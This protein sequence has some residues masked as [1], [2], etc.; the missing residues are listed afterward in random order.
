[1]IREPLEAIQQV[2]AEAREEDFVLVSGSVY[3]VGEIYPYFL[4]AQGRSRLFPE[5]V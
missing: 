4:A 3:L 5:A 2:M 1:M